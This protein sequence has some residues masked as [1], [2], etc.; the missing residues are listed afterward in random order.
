MKRSRA[1]IAAQPRAKNAEPVLL[2]VRKFAT[3]VGPVGDD[4][5]FLRQTGKFDEGVPEAGTLGGSGRCQSGGAASTFAL[6][7]IT[8]GV[9]N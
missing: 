8:I 4:C 1:I 5:C 9:D 2:R 3:F 7:N 6:D